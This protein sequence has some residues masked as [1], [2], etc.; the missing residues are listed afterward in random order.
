MFVTP[1]VQGPDREISF[2]VS[3][4]ESATVPTA[5]EPV[6]EVCGGELS[7]DVNQRIYDLEQE[8][9]YTKENLQ[10][11]IE[12]LETSNEELQSTNEELQSVNEELVTVNSEYQEKIDE[13]TELNNDINNLLASTEVGTLFLDRE[14]NIRKFTPV[15]TREINILEQDV[16][17]PPKHIAAALEA[18]GLPAVAEKVLLTQRQV[19]HEV[20]NKDGKQYLL[21]CLPYLTDERNIEG[22]V[23]TLIDIDAMKKANR[24]LQKLSYAVEQ[25]PAM[26][27]ITDTAGGIEYVNP[28]FETVTGYALD[29]V[30]GQNPRLLKTGVLPREFYRKLWETISAGRKWSGVFQNRKKDGDIYWEEATVGPISDGAGDEPARFLKIS[31]NITEKKHIADQLAWSQY[32][33]ENATDAMFRVS[34]SGDIDHVNQAAMDLLG[35]SRRSFTARKFYRLLDGVDRDRWRAFAERLV[36]EPHVQQEFA[37]IDRGERRISVG[38]GFHRLEQEGHE[39]LLAFMKDLTAIRE[40]ERELAEV[41]ETLR[42]SQRLTQAGHFVFHADTNELSWSDELYHL[43]EMKPGEQRIDRNFFLSLASD[44]SD[45]CRLERV[46]NGDRE[47]G[48]TET[49]CLRTFTGNTVTFHL[50]AESRPAEDDCRSCSY[51]TVQVLTAEGGEDD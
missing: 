31:E 4:V 33:I 28:R 42:W 24:E 30:K 41:R 8:L 27:L 12:E 36:H 7:N 22:V 20:H 39:Y 9:R 29:E 1:L 19:E 51:G 34:P 38:I 3:F 44:S 10:A 35:Y 13:L 15:I 11:T 16:G 6:E 37:A 21:R 49:V 18:V 5:G 32:A 25:S 40:A 45:R 43:L 23:I 2:L 48:E 17:R 26:V 50:R 14:L 47:A 46:L